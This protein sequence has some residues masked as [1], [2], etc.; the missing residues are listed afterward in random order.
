MNNTSR[1][2]DKGDIYA[3]TR[4]GYAAGLFDFIKNTLT[5]PADSTFA[6]IG[7]G[8]GIFSDLLLKSGY[9]V[10]AV[11]PNEDMRRKADEKLS[12]YNGFTSVNGTADNTTL[13]KRSVDCVSTAQAFHWFNAETF[14]SEC[15]RILKPG[16]KV[17]IVYN[18]RN[19]NNS[20]NK[21]LAD[22]CSR[23]CP[24]FH[25]FSNGMNERK[26]LDFFDNE[27]K[28]FRAE[29]NQT[30][31]RQGFINRTLSSSYSLCETDNNFTDYLV[32][33]N[34]LFDYFSVHGTLTV[35]VS[36]VAYAGQV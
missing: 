3:K 8:T 26:C 2:D 32:E 4:P 5:V 14:K 33:I 18:T 11:E 12:I 27:C 28:I 16:G 20:C 24:E 31:N 9:K 29:N 30:Y 21:A 17:I 1:F 25:G 23:Y 7:S 34:K 15:R 10:Y 13:A 6:D 22:I 35:P 19:E 36:T